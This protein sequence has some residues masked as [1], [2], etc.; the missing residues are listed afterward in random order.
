[1]SKPKKGDVVTVRLVGPGVTTN[2]LDSI[3]KVTK[4]KLWI[5]AAEPFDHSGKYLGFQIPGFC[6]SVLFD[7][8]KACG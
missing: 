6:M 4:G 5:S 1:M 7:G 8:G 3:V 2:E